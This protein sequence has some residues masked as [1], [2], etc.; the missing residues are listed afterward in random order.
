MDLTAP[1]LAACDSGRQ[2]PP[3]SAPDY[4]EQLTAVI[5]EEEVELVFSLNDLELELLSH[6]REAIEAETDALLY[7]PPKDTVSFTS[8]K[9]RTFTFS[10]EHGIPV[11]ATFLTV[12]DALAAIHS[13][14]IA[15]PLI[16]K[17][18]WGSASIGLFRAESVD[19]LHA[20]VASCHT[21]LAKSALAQFGSDQ[22]VII[23]EL[24]GGSEYGVDILYG[25]EENLIGFAAKRKLT[26]RAGETDKSVTVDPDRFEPIVSRIAQG[27]RHR[28]NLDCDFL[29][30]DG[31]LH[32]LEMNPRFGGG[33]PFTHLAGANHVAML[34]ADFEGKPLPPYRYDVGRAFAKY[35][36]LVET[37][38]PSVPKE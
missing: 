23:Q 14:E 24:L 4:L 31:E 16:V 34:L 36:M 19:E 10:R 18:R 30:R 6:N 35:D 5:R 20:A 11:P 8:D 29:E 9:W 37:P 22:A 13:D 27:L 26:M 7:V 38:A 17:P 28:G 15:F 2:V 21:A 25:R 3:S 32:L 12:S 33:Y 1:A